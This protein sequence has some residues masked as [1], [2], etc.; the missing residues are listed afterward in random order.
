[1]R[2]DKRFIRKGGALC[3]VEVSLNPVGEAD[4]R[5]DPSQLENR[6]RL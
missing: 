4:L 1:M 5:D 6:G 3:S 2:F